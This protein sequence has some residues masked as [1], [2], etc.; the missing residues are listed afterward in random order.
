LDEVV[1]A[2]RQEADAD[3]GIKSN[4]QWHLFRYFVALLEGGDAGAVD[5]ANA[6]ASH[7]TAGIMETLDRIIKD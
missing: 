2:A 5:G 1:Q 6:G 3:L 4:V 7:Y